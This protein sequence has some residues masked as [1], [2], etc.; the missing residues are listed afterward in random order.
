MGGGT[1]KSQS[2]PKRTVSAS[3]NRIAKVWCISHGCYFSWNYRKSWNWKYHKMSDS[4]ILMKFLHKTPQFLKSWI[5]PLTCMILRVIAYLSLEQ[6]DES[7]CWHLLT[8]IDIFNIFLSTFSTRMTFFGS[9]QPA[10][11]VR[12]WFSINIKWLL[13]NIKNC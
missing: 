3:E 7:S 11:V 8:F 4:F 2:L 10:L 1:L 5:V 13:N 9:H 12:W 6:F